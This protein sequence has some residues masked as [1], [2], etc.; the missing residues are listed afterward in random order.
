MQLKTILVLGVLL[1]SNPVWAESVTG[2]VKKQETI[3]EK[4]EPSVYERR[5]KRDEPEVYKQLFS[6]LENNGYFVVFE[7]NIGKNLSRFSQRW[8][9]DYNKNKLDSIRS[10]IF[11]NGW[12]ANK[13]SNADPKMLA[14][15]PMHI[16]ITHKKGITSILYV[17][18]GQVAKAS[19]AKKVADELEQDVIRIINSIP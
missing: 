11:C 12:Y 9:D 18:P 10:M 2:P 15:C 8:G 13:V 3:T 7:T 14:L 16:T 6:A 5:I 4:L 17:R 19:P 1:V